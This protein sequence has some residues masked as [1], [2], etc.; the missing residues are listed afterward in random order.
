MAAARVEAKRAAKRSRSPAMPGWSSRQALA[1]ACASAEGGLAGQ[2]ERA[3][4]F[5]N[6]GR[7]DRLGKPAC[8]EQSRLSRRKG[9]G[10]RGLD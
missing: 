8:C 6:N 10:L 4:A 5:G 9:G 7:R 3:A 1:S 2:G